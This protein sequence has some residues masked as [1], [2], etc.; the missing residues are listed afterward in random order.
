METVGEGDYGGP[1]EATVRR[2]MEAFAGRTGLSREGAQRRYLWT[3]SFA[4]CNYLTLFRRT[5]DSR[6]REL[7]IILMDRVHHVLGRHREDDRRRGWISGL[8][9]TEG[10]RHPTAGGLRIGKD[11]NERGPEEAYD[12]RLEWDRD[13]QYYH[14]L[15][16]WMHALG[17]AADVLGEPHYHAWAVELAR[18]ACEGFV[19]T[20]VPGE[21]ARM[22][23]KMSIDLSRPL[24]PS[25]GAHDPLD[26]LVTLCSL[27]A[28]AS[29][30]SNG[31]APQL[32]QETAELG[33]MC[34]GQNWA[35]DD[36]L[37][38]GGLLTSTCRVTRLLSTE[39]ADH[40]ILEPLL[41]RLV[42]DSLV[43]LEA[44][45]RTSVLRLPP[46]HRLAFR[47][48]GLA[49]GLRAVEALQASAGTGGPL[50]RIGELERYLGLIDGITS[51][52]LSE[53][54]RADV[55]WKAHE[56]INEVMLA[57]ALVPDEYIMV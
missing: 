37:G 40:K 44:M 48:L 12:P 8:D 54:G 3:D 9:E 56:D 53:A 18:A 5:G 38:I 19:Y 35:T 22:H 47:E 27:R 13:G 16:Q 10:E 2:L 31:V 15:T 21:P 43:S 49:I 6:F 11:L 30:H 32:E 39:C 20:P 36:P 50:A 46:A 25:Q 41:A 14:Y 45:A 4:V 28:A 1:D 57:T 33:R 52:W 51:V 34:A 23:W 26:G 55:S 42:D 7:S 29:R 17:R 24:V